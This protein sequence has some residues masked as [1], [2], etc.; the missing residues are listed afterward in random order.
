MAIAVSIKRRD[1]GV[2]G[3]LLTKRLWRGFVTKDIMRTPL[4]F[5]CP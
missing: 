4:L 3:R 2:M 1:K 5:G